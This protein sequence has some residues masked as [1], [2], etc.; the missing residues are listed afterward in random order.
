MTTKRSAD[1]DD[2]VG[3]QRQ[4]EVELLNPTDF[5]KPE[6][7][8]YTFKILDLIN[9]RSTVYVQKLYDESSIVKNAY[10]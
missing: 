9:C 8:N 6:F 4:I 7:V 1:V 10:Y 5:S 3:V 2:E